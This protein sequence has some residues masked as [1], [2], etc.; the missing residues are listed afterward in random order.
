MCSVV[1]EPWC[2]ESFRPTECHTARLFDAECK[3]ATAGALS[4][5]AHAPREMFHQSGLCAWL[6]LRLPTQSSVREPARR[7][8]SGAPSGASGEDVPNGN[9]RAWNCPCRRVSHFGQAIKQARC[10]HAARAGRDKKIHVRGEYFPRKIEKKFFRNSA[11]SARRGKSEF[12]RFS[13]ARAG[14]SAQADE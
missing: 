13:E 6:L 9:W 7:P 8:Y 14:F 5:L 10:Q 4:P 2:A 12:H 3:L 11:T 1:V